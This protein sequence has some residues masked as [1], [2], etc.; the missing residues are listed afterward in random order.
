MQQTHNMSVCVCVCERRMDGWWREKIISQKLWPMFLKPGIIADVYFAVFL[1]PVI[2]LCLSA[3]F[4]LFSST[5]LIFIYLFPASVS[6]GPVPLVQPSAGMLWCLSTQQVILCITVLL[7][8]H[9][10]A[11]WG[12]M[13]G[14]IELFCVVFRPFLICSCTFLC[15]LTFVTACFFTFHCGL[16]QSVVCTC[17]SVITDICC[18][19]VDAFCHFQLFVSICF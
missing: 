16:R 1:P 8:S 6:T 2:V 3:F 7:Q 14:W 18:R 15:C 4:Y 19:L 12:S 5:S 9:C 17:C 10:E 11:G 13:C